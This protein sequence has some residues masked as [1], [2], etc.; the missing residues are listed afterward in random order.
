MMLTSNLIKMR[1]NI[2]PD[3]ILAKD[4]IDEYE[5][6]QYRKGIETRNSQIEKMGIERLYAR[7]NIG[8]EIKVQASVFALSV[9][10]LNY[11]FPQ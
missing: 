2:I 8:F 10:I 4:R 6:K 9:T 5:L 3:V 7:T 1:L 11:S